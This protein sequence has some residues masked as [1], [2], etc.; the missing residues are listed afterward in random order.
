MFI[1]VIIFFQI[2]YDRNLITQ[3]Q[4]ITMQKEK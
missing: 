4:G 1:N 3:G 2:R